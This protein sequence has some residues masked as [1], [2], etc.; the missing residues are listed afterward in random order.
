MRTLSVLLVAGLLAQTSA[1]AQEAAP[2]DAPVIAPED[3]A[4]ENAQ[5]APSALTMERARALF[6]AGSA[7]VEA[8]DYEGAFRYFTESYELSRLPRM[9]FN[10][11][12]AAERMQHSAEAL[13]FYRQFLEEVPNA[14][15]RQFAEGRIRALEAVVAEAEAAQN[16]AGEQDS[17][18][19][20]MPA[21]PEQQ[22]TPASA[23]VLLGGGVAAVVGGGVL[24]ATGAAKRAELDDAPEG[25]PFAE[26]DGH[27]SSANLQTGLGIGLLAAGALSATVG[28]VI[29][30]SSGSN[31]DD[32]Q[33]VLGVNRVSVRGSF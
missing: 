24:L 27:A 13:G 18:T 25:A 17:E 4:P 28:L 33:V 20:A 29:M 9:L 12:S 22:G 1:S 30:V 14:R 7:A 8:G 3:T 16:G 26:F 21:E 2:E 23:W 31:E 5:D 32:T 6:D 19:N 15:N 10:L 11:G